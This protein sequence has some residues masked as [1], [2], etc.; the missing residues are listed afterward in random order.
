MPRAKHVPR[1]LLPNVVSKWRN[2]SVFG[3]L[4]KVCQSNLLPGMKEFSKTILIL[5]ETCEI[6]KSCHILK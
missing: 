4:K 5:H 2:S 3:R 1:L 6:L